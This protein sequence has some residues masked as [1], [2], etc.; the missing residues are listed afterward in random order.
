MVETIFDILRE[1]GPM[2]IGFAASTLWSRTEQRKKLGLWKVML[3]V[4]TTGILYS[5]VLGENRGDIR[6]GIAAAMFD[7][8]TT[9]LGVWLGQASTARWVQS[10][11]IALRS[12]R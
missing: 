1:C 9:G 10:F 6:D 4:L 2:I 8:A 3:A 7:S 11:A 12:G 5:A